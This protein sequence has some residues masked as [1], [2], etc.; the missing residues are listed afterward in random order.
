ME[1]QDQEGKK[2]HGK[3]DVRVMTIKKRNALCIFKMD[4]FV[5]QIAM[6]FRFFLQIFKKLNL[7][8]DTG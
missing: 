7:L 5:N 4:D 1:I 8:G 6:T 2:E 3:K